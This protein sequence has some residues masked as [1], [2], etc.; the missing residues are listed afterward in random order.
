MRK[1]TALN[2]FLSAT[3]TTAGLSGI[4]STKDE[5]VFAGHDS[6]AMNIRV[7]NMAGTNPSLFI[8]LM[9]RQLVSGT[10]RM[11]ASFGPYTALGDYSVR[12]PQLTENLIRIDALGYGTSINIQ[13]QISLILGSVI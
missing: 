7:T 10:Y 6:L 4:L 1:V 2:N 5:G 11:I 13:V 12:I 9:A 8:R 3:I